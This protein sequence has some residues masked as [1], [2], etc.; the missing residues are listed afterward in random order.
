[1]THKKHSRHYS[2]IGHRG[3]A[4]AEAH[5]ESPIACGRARGR[6]RGRALAKRRILVSLAIASQ[7]APL[8]AT[9]SDKNQ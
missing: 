8:S 7:L 2:L 5:K 6:G 1:M 3:A 4:S 9:T